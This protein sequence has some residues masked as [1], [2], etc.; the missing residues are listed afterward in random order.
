LAGFKFGGGGGNRTP[1]PFKNSIK[2]HYLMNQG[3][4]KRTQYRHND[5]T[6]MIEM[7]N[8]KTNPTADFRIEKRR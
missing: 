7:S 2:K 4:K 3:K 5:M 8:H 1:V 6:K